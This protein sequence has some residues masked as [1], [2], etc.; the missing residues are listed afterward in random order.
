MRHARE[1]QSVAAG[2]SKDGEGCRGRRAP[3]SAAARVRGEGEDFSSSFEE[4]KGEVSSAC[5]RQSEWEAKVVAGI[6]AMVEFAAANPAK[7]LA[8]SVEA[9]RPSADDRIPANEVI[10]YF[11]RRLAEVAPSQKRTPISNDMAIVEAIALIVRGHL[12]GGTA[13]QLPGAAPD[14][15]YLALMPYLGLAET[16]GWT[17]ALALGKK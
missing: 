10:A 11:A 17:N 4:L 3:V 14:L 2:R 16:R 5:E 6:Q 13:G 8:L 15:A 7:A 12:L 1:R 9:R